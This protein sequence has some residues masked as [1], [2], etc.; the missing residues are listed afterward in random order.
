MERIR[1]HIINNILSEEERDIL[2]LREK[3]ETY[4]ELWRIYGKDR[5]TILRRISKIERIIKAETKKLIDF[6]N[7]L[8]NFSE[9]DWEKLDI[10]F[11]KELKEEELHIKNERW[12][13]VKWFDHEIY[14]SNLWRIKRKKDDVEKIIDWSCHS[15][16]YRISL[17]KDGISKA[18]M[19]HRIIAEAFYWE[20]PEG[21][22]V[23]HK[24]WNKINNKASNLEIVSAS[25]NVIHAYETWLNSSPVPVKM[26]TLDN[27]FIK[28]FKSISDASRYSG[29]S[30][31]DIWYICIGSKKPKK[32][33]FEHT[34]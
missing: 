11:E 26:Y 18:Y 29:I 25:E 14:A 12:K 4:E 27:K 20:I 9:W 30:K 5:T 15:W 23:N 33:I 32:Y 22:H 10:F 19:K 21:Y 17:K 16:Y 1:Q 34:N 2:F 7:M 28:K 8:V 13:E 3:G 24:D 31:Q 6:R